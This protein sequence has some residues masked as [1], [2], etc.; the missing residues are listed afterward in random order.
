MVSVVALASACYFYFH[1]APNFTDKDTIVL[2]DF[3]NK[4][5]TLFLTAR[6]VRAWRCNS[7]NPLS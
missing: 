5:G 1:R 2:S 3:D 4:T 6:F 7:N